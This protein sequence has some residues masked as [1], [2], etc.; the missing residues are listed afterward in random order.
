MRWSKQGLVIEAPTHLAW[1]HSHAAV[2][3]AEIADGGRLAVYF[4]TRDSHRRSHIAYAELELGS[5]P[6]LAALR[7]DPVLRPGELG[8]FDDS[9]VM[10]SCLV[11]HDGRQYLYY[12]GWSLG[13]TVPF[14]VLIG[15]A[16]KDAGANQFERVSAAPLIGRNAVDPFMCSSPWV[17]VEDGL[18][19]MWYV[20]NLGWTSRDGEPPQYRVHIRYAESTDGLAWQRDG[21]VCIDFRD[22]AEYAIS[23]PC[24][25]KDGD[26][27][28]MWY[29][30]RGPSYRIG[31]AESSDGLTWVRR[32]DQVGIDV[33]PGGWDSEMVEYACVFD[34]DGRRHMLYN[35]NGF[36]RT[37]IGHAILVENSGEPASPAR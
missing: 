34:H 14:Y 8:A 22:V 37:G 5:P 25:L 29:S 13:V 24:V 11:H 19:R 10:T 36:G 16:V 18:W 2:P 20:S 23:R 21:H 15:C 33:S 28:R 4:T 32:D 9:G 26:L 12:Q 35:G 31:Y 7:F 3:H 17:L 1:S 30:F 27:Y 6:R